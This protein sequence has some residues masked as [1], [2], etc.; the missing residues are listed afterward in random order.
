M[1]AGLVWFGFCLPDPLFQS[2]TSYIIE[3]AEGE[4]LG[5]TI[6]SDGQWRFPYNENIPEKFRQCIISFEDKRFRHHPGIDPLAIFR[7]L[8]QNIQSSQTVSG[9]STITMQVIRLSRNKNRNV[10][11][12][13]IESILAVRLEMARSKE[14]ILA[15]YASHAPFG[16]N[17]V[18][19]DAAAWRYYG[20]APD[21]LSWGETAALAVLPNAPAL[22]HP[23]KNRESLLKKRNRLLDKLQAEK[24]IDST[25]CALAK[26]EPLP[27]APKP[28]PQLAPHL[29]QRFKQEAAPG[30][31][32]RVQTTIN[33]NLQ[34]TVTQI[35]EQ[36]HR[37]LK[38]NGI[39]NACA[40]V[41]EVET[42]K[43]L[44][45]VG[46]AYHPENIT[47]QSSVDIITSRR[48][49]GSALKPILYAGMLTDGL[50]LPHTL[51]PD[52]PT[53]IGGYTPQNF[54]YDYDGA[55]P[56]SRALLRSL[57]V[58]AV[59]MLR[60]YKYPRFYDLLK[61]TGITTLNQPADH[62]GLSLI[63]GGCEV[64]PWGMAGLYAGMARALKHAKK[65]NG[66]VLAKD[67][68]APYYLDAASRQNSP[69]TT[70][71]ART[72]TFNFV[73]PV[74]IWYMFQAM[75][76]VM[77]PGEEGL[78]K[79]FGS[80]QRVAWKTGTSFGFRDA[81]AIGVTPRFVIAVWAGNGSGEG[82]PGLI[83]VQAAAPILFDIVRALPASPWFA[84]PAL[85]YTNITVCRQTGFRANTDCTDIDTLKASPNAINGPLCPYHT[86]I[87]L[88]ADQQYRVTE[89]CVSPS[90]MVHKSWLVLP[91]AM[92][93]YYKRK[94]FDYQPVP[95]YKPG[96]AAWDSHKPM[97]LIY[98][99]PDAKIY[100]P[101]EISGQKGRTVFTA[102]HQKP[103]AKIFWHL[104]DTYI[105]TTVHTHQMALDPNP[106]THFVTIVDETG[107]RIT[108]Q[109]VILEKED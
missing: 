108:R 7:A 27:Q 26:L 78:W 97:A 2:P 35:V 94:H 6:A 70:L 44:A 10:F 96:C 21:K 68:H 99:E 60:D 19:L 39:N 41:L 59:R 37:F 98:P 83:G 48:S 13:L 17:V 12:K 51:V 80:A 31:Y 50:L 52:I 8:Q 28:L 64:T 9:G 106:G 77:R 29:L 84:E 105:G 5:A 47:L 69:S 109:F 62:Y 55:V 66:K 65:N 3:D 53:Q 71:A 45:Y 4:L 82:R 86:V 103:E 18:G 90:A 61:K 20:R 81:W 88:D 67:F 73:D 101:R 87:H 43:T 79:Q 92:E 14:S 74:S 89:N 85:Q 107:E 104:D 57:N 23:G 58:P 32:T 42:G 93:W 102:A 25:T 63:L 16:S 36:H 76:E 72:A 56:A 38:G 95:P 24:K 33:R 15:L 49:P 100:V 11:Q 40:L 34:N 1:I 91:P 22:V 54:D 46:N 75:E 30:T